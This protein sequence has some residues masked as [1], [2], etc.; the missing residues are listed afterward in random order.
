MGDGYRVNK[1]TYYIGRRRKRK[2]SLI[3]FLGSIL[4]QKPLRKKPSLTPCTKPF[5]EERGS[6]AGALVIGP[7][8]ENLVRY[9]VI[10]NDYW[11]SL[12]RTGVGVITGSKKLKARN[13][14]RFMPFVVSAWS[15][16]LRKSSTSMISLIAL[17]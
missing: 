4:K 17:V 8:G 3:G 1:L 6:G 10:E 12:G 2:A 13:M 15:I 7:A 16:K 11:R 5:W 14:R 9:A